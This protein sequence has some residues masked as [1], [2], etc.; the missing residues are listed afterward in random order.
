[1]APNIQYFYRTFSQLQACFWVPLLVAYIVNI[2][3]LP[4]ACVWT[5]A[6]FSFHEKKTK[7]V[8][9]HSG[10]SKVVSERNKWFLFNFSMIPMVCVC[11]W[12]KMCVYFV[13][14]DAQ[15]DTL[16]GNGAKNTTTSHIMDAD[17]LL[18]PAP[19]DRSSK[20]PMFV[21][22]CFLMK[23][24]CEWVDPILQDLLCCFKL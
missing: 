15:F 23:L 21:Y 6:T 2:Y 22:F 5:G 11:V 1:M 10:Q 24:F 12:H 13:A 4:R 16:S 14:G 8:L 9:S 20:V 18:F 19:K 7:S 3:I 17:K